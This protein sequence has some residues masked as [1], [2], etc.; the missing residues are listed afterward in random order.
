MQAQ[1]NLNRIIIDDALQQQNP[2]P[3]AFGRAAPRSA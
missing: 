2:D 1:N 3:I